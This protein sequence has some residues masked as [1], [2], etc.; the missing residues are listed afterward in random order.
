M[1]VLL[2]RAPS[3]RRKASK[4]PADAPI[5]TI[6]NW[7]CVGGW[8]TIL[9]GSER[10]LDLVNQGPFDA[11]RRA[12]L[13]ALLAGQGRDRRYQCRGCNRL[14]EQHPKARGQR[15]PQILTWRIS[16]K[17][18]RRGSVLAFSGNHVPHQVVAAAS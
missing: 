18:S 12:A 3:R 9:V 15:L 7:P 8:V 4:P 17:R 16:R 10:G 5:P 2:G 14:L 1:P 11:Q 6:G 13:A